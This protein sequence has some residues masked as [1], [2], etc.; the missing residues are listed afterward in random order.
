MSIRRD[1]MFLFNFRPQFLS[2]K[3]ALLR[4]R[5]VAA[6]FGTINVAQKV[7]EETLSWYSP[8][9]FYPVRIGETFKSKYRVLSKLGY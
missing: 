7:E 1:S 5:P 4:H 6:R 2:M 3:P 8:E 9:D